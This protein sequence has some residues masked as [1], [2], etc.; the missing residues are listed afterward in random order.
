[1]SDTTKPT[2]REQALEARLSGMLL[3]RSETSDG[4]IMLRC[5][6]EEIADAERLLALPV[7]A[8][9]DDPAWSEY[10]SA[11]EWCAKRGFRGDICDP[12]PE[13]LS[14]KVCG[15]IDADPEAFGRR[16]RESAYA[17]AATRADGAG[18]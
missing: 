4:A 11:A 2:T 3:V 18:K 17:L 16:V 6:P 9:A 7:E 12:L 5:T 10:D 8:P 14:A 1:M 13:G 15:L